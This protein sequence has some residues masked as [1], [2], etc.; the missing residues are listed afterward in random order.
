MWSIL[1]MRSVCVVRYGDMLF[2]VMHGGVYGQTHLNL[3]Y[4]FFLNFISL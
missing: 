2:D 3:F 1:K 4:L